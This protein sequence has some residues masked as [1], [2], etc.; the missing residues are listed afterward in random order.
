MKYYF[1]I[2]TGDRV[3]S[4]TISDITVVLYGEK[5][6]T[7]EKSLRAYASG[8]PFERN[9]IDYFEVDFCFDVG[10]VNQISLKK[11]TQVYL[12]NGW[13]C[14]YILVSKQPFSE[15]QSQCSIFKIN[16]WLIL[17]GSSGTYDV[18]E[19]YP[20][21]I[22]PPTSSIEEFS[23]GTITVP[24]NTVYDKTVSCGLTISVDYSTVKTIDVSTGIDINLSESALN[25][26]FSKHIN[27]SIT[28]TTNITLNKTEEYTD[29]INIGP[30]EK[31]VVY[32]V[33][34]NKLIY[35]FDI[36]MGEVHFCFK[37]PYKEQFAG[38]KEISSGKVINANQIILPIK[39][40][41]LFKSIGIALTR[42]CN[43]ACRMC[44]F[45]C[46]MNREETLQEQEV[47]N[48]I[49]QA[50]EIDGISRIGFSG[51]EV[52]LYPEVLLSCLDKAKKSG[53]ETSITSNGFWG[54]DSVNC[55]R[56]LNSFKNVD[57]NSLTISIDQYHLEFVSIECITNII[58][59]NRKVGIPLLLAIG[60]SL[61]GKSAVDIIKELSED[62]YT[63][64]IVIYPFMPVGRGKNISDSAIKYIPYDKNWRC[65]NNNQLAILYNG[66]VFPCCSQAVYNSKLSMGNIKNHPLKEIVNKYSNQ[67]IFST[68]KR[69]GLDWFVKL[70]KNEMG[71]N[72]PNQYHSPCHLC[73]ILFSNK[74]FIDNIDTYI[75]K[76]YDRTFI[77]FLGI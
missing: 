6:Q 27:K 40:I 47:F 42:K 61:E 34:W 75:Q 77:E 21:T 18:S 56:V 9:A 35:N 33:L 71:I 69:R 38:L 10:Y 28:E 70:A 59:E 2:H 7:E 20:Y 15:K 32:E 23:T 17:P 50:K 1:K 43:A 5:G 39:S 19:G 63:N 76:E 3:N 46:N 41:P 12:L 68:L 4:G 62:I 14:D 30:F 48:I 60:N 29:T 72:L 51:G 73:N 49:D 54:K 13:L 74:K 64:T 45:E 25:S 58:R 65:N 31:T 16:D 44:C 55:L 67:C 26:A 57:L 66:D 22:S 52:M 8:K 53:M 36:I 24:H 11:D 37:V